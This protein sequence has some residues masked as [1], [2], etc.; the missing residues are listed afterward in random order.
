MWE[1]THDHSAQSRR[2]R[3]ISQGTRPSPDARFTFQTFDDDKKRKKARAEA[4]KLRKKEGKKPLPDPFAKIRHG[5]LADHYDM[6][7][8]LNAKGAGIF[9]TVNETDCKGREKD[10]VVRVRAVFTDL[11]GAPLDQVIV[12]TA[13]QPHIITETS[14]ERWHIY[15]RVD[16]DPPIEGAGADAKK[17][18]LE[19]FS[20]EQKAIAARSAATAVC[21]ISPA[22]CA[23]PASFTAKASRSSR[24]SSRSTVL[25]RVTGTK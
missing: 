24:A 22:S 5:T 23:C 8:K 6:L 4:N 9:V 1:G 18:M 19:Q 10:N 12:E 3:A 21:T 16:P 20:E 14:P 15:W 11:D 13:L 25:S 2:G 7:A 17:K